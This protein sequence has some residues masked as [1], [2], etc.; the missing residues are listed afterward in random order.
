MKFTVGVTRTL[1]MVVGVWGRNKREAGSDRERF[2]A[3][4]DIC[5]QTLA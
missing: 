3:H 4:A 2:R 5:I 1:G